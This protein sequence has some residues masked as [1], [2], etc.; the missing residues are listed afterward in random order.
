M[1]ESVL[2][3]CLAH[4]WAL[5]KELAVSLCK[6]HWANVPS[7]HKEGCWSVLGNGEGVASDVSG[8]GVLAKCLGG[9]TDLGPD[10][11]VDGLLPCKV[12]KVRNQE[13]CIG[14][15]IVFGDDVLKGGVFENLL[16]FQQWSPEGDVMDHLFYMLRDLAEAQIDW[17]DSP[18][19]CTGIA[20]GG[21]DVAKVG[22][23]IGTA[24]NLHLLRIPDRVRD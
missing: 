8:N 16:H 15:A 18:G 9:L 6:S 12:F 20:V 21:E 13:V 1:F 22:I 23:V 10:L 3:P 5:A 17:I 4:L 14:L 24:T 2:P 7:R 11:A 19:P